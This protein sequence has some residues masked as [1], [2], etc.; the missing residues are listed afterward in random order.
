MQTE[1][2]KRTDPVTKKQVAVPVQVP[3]HIFRFTRTTS[4]RRLKAIGELTLI[5]F[6]FLLRVGEYTH[7]GKGVRRTQQ[8]RLCDMKF[9]INERRIM[10]DQLAQHFQQINLVCL[11]MDNQKNGNRGQSLSHHALMGDNQCCPVKAVVARAIDMVRDGATPETLICAFKDAP[12]LPW[13]QV[14]SQDIV[15]V[16]KDALPAVGLKNSR[17]E[18]S[19][20]GSHSLRAGGAMALYLNSHTTLEI[21][22]AGRWTSATF[23]EYIHSQLSATTRGLAQSMS[24]AVPSINMA[25]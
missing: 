19:D 8:F 23:L 25:R 16:V 13:Q 7:H 21:Q 3:N 1:T 17:F 12:S 9:F 24:I 6:Y 20:V 10:P 14:R 11:T 4:D 18:R 2:Y 22:R 5:A 15:N